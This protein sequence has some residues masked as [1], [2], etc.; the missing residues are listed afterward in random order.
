MKWLKERLVNI[1]DW[2]NGLLPSR[3]LMI[4]QLLTMGMLA[5]GVPAHIATMG[6]AIFGSAGT[7]PVPVIVPPVPVQIG[8]VD[9]DKLLEGIINSIRPES[10]SRDTQAPPEAGK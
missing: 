4:A 5:V 2:Y 1:G 9:D 10:G 7:A 6:G 3:R 8:T